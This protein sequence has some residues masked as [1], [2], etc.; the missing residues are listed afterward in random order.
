MKLD[1]FLR[2]ALDRAE[3]G[4]GGVMGNQPGCRG[5]R[6]LTVNGEALAWVTDDLMERLPNI[7]CSELFLAGRLTDA[8]VGLSDVEISLLGDWR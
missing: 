1:E 6:T 8:L 4:G 5:A 7:E 2:E 3:G